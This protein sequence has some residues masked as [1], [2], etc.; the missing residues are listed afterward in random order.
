MTGWSWWSFCKFI[1]VKRDGILTISLMR[2]RFG[3]QEILSTEPTEWN[4]RRRMNGSDWFLNL[5]Q[6]FKCNQAITGIIIAASEQHHHKK[7]RKKGMIPLHLWYIVPSLFQ[8]NVI[9][10]SCVAR[11]FK[12]EVRSEVRNLQRHWG[13]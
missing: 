6:S 7:L 4:R 9:Y 1:A 8:N 5:F 3:N 12:T 2:I 10:Q 11:I 13:M